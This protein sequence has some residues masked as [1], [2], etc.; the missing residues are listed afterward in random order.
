M[1]GHGEILA[2]SSGCYATDRRIGGHHGDDELRKALPAAKVH[3]VASRAKADETI[4]DAAY[5]PTV[6]VISNDRYGDYCEKAPVKEQRVVRHESRTAA[7]WSTTSAFRLPLSPAVACEARAC[8]SAGVRDQGG[9]TSAIKS[10]HWLC[11][12]G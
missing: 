8:Q 7:S 2:I 10:I 1:V 11:A 3:V 9:S 6:W 4:L 12:A 5:E